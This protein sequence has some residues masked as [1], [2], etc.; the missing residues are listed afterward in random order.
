[1]AIQMPTGAKATAALSFAFVAWL[2]ANVYVP[3]MPDARTVGYFREYMGILGAIVGWQV[4][5]TSVGKGYRAA[6]GTGLKT[7]IVIIFFGLLLF[8]IYEMLMQSVRMRYDGPFEA[9]MD[10]FV[11]MA[12]RARALFSLWVIVVVVVGGVIGGI[13]TENANRRWR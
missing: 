4:M 10:V 11:R 9:V 2:L 13:V 8:S 3:Y 7:V 5:G 6:A 12:F 1:M